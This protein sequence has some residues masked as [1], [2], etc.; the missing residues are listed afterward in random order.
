MSAQ[1]SNDNSQ[2]KQEEIKWKIQRIELL[3]SS[4]SEEVESAKEMLFSRFKRYP[5]G[6][7]EARLRLLG[8]VTFSIPLILGFRDFPELAGMRPYLLILMAAV[9]G[10]GILVFFKYESRIKTVNN[11]LDKIEN[12][13]EAVKYRIN[14]QKGIVISLTKNIQEVKPPTVD[15]LFD[16]RQQL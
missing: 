1:S 9:I 5:E 6:L 8:I 10:S 4:A 13:Y 12:G 3:L 11:L 15:F 14:I 2:I 7:R 16:W